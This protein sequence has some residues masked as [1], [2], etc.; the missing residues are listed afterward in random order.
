MANDV[1]WRLNEFKNSI[2]S[3]EKHENSGLK[4]WAITKRGDIYALS[5][6]LWHAYGRGRAE[7]KKI[8][9]AHK[10]NEPSELLFRELIN[11]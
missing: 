1:T 10:I 4:T 11:S 6:G 7:L 9:Q 2:V 3:N 5:D 8:L